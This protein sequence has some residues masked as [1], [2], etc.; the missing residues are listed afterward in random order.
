VFCQRQAGVN[1]VL[2]ERHK[3]YSHQMPD[4]SLN[5]HQIQF[6]FRWGSAPDPS[7]ELIALPRPPRFGEGRRRRKGVRGEMG[8]EG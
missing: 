3:K 8:R 5:M 1:T 7:R 4:F 2:H 6:I